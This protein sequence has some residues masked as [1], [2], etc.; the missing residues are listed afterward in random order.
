LQ[1]SR[2]IAEDNLKKYNDHYYHRDHFKILGVDVKTISHIDD[3]ETIK[4]DINDSEFQRNIDEFFQG[5]KIDLILS[6]ASINKS[7][8]KFS[9]QLRQIRLCYNVLEIA[10]FN[11]KHKGILLIKIFQGQDFDK[12]LNDMKKEFLYVKSYKPMASK[13]KSNEIYLIGFKKK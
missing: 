2:K 3:V 13:K 11:L 9:D 4:I 7:G 6:D 12:F 10:K 1:V 8:N 5:K